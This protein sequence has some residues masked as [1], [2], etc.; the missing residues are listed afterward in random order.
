MQH[1]PRH[2]T[3]QRAISQGKKEGYRIITTSRVR[4]TARGMKVLP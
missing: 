1:E 2:G 3:A 4:F